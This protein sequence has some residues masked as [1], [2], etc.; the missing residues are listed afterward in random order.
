ML[1][2]EVVH[3]IKDKKSI[4][5]KITRLFGGD[6]G[7]APVSGYELNRLN[8]AAGN[9]P[10]SQVNEEMLYFVDPQKLSAMLGKVA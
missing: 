1:S 10:N 6:S 4:L 5:G 2:N 3:L 9:P 8:K 7:N